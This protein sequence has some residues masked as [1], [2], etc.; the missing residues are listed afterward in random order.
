M[1]TLTTYGYIL[2]SFDK[3]ETIL[4]VRSIADYPCDEVFF[5]STQD[6]S[7][8]KKEFEQ[9]LSLIEE[10]DVIVV[11]SL[12]C[13]GKNLFRLHELFHLLIEKQINLISISDNFSLSENPTNDFVS[14]LNFL[15]NLERDIIQK[16]TNHGINQA[17]LEGRFGGRPSLDESTIS[18]ILSLRKQRHSIRKISTICGVS[19]GTVHKY[20]STEANECSSTMPTVK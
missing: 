10:D 19:V 17:K 16:R 12:N 11:H 9:L 1:F 20:L 7:V 18:Q 14:T 13:L 5:E 8:E 2:E 4:Q 3:S 15:V 6:D